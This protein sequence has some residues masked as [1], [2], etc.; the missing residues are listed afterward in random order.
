KEPDAPVPVVDSAAQAKA[1]GKKKRG[2]VVSELVYRAVAASQ[3]RKGLFYTIKQAL[4]FQGYDVNQHGFLV[5]RAINMLVKKGA[6]IQ[7]K[8]S[9]AA[10]SSESASKKKA[11]ARRRCLRSSKGS[12]KSHQTVHYRA[13]F[14]FK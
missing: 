14:I 5:K 2:P 10:G 9:G 3:D 11:L 7:T 12:F 1:S 4:S 6:L 8:G 13:D